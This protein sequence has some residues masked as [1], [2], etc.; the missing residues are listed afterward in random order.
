[1]GDVEVGIGPRRWAIVGADAKSITRMER[2]HK[3]LIMETLWTI[4]WSCYCDYGERQVLGC[5][6]S[7]DSE[8]EVG[9]IDDG[10]M[11]AR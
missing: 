4:P 1:M 10:L 7:L 11:N 9:W 3:S 5:S 2:L 8:L 6:G